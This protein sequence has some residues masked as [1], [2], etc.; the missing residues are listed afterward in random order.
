M[1]DHEAVMACCVDEAEASE[2]EDDMGV[3]IAELHCHGTSTVWN[4]SYQ[5]PSSKRAATFIC[6]YSGC[7]KTYATSNAAR[8]HVRKYHPEW[9]KMVELQKR[10]I[11]GYCKRVR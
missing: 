7:G 1:A 5:Q 8:K 10:G 4:P 2:A 11:D 3:D 6:R 9:L